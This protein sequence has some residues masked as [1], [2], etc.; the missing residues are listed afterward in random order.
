[1]VDGV[2]VLARVGRIGPVHPA[3]A[4]V[5]AEPEVGQR[6]VQ[7]RAGGFQFRHRIRKV[8][9]ADRARVDIRRGSV[10]LA[11]VQPGRNLVH[12]AVVGVD[13]V[14]VRGHPERGLVQ[15]C[16]WRGRQ[17][18]LTAG[19]DAGQRDAAR[20]HVPRRAAAAEN[21]R[22]RHGPRARS[23]LAYGALD[24]MRTGNGQRLMIRSGGRD[25]A[26]PHRVRQFRPDNQ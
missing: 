17:L 5:A 11:H 7:P 1:M 3:A 9:L 16:G 26:Q 18:H 25:L 14:L 10:G 20:E 22:R 4:V 8:R 13:H 12:A 24:Q 2:Q 15:H 23:G 6:A 19:A 21:R